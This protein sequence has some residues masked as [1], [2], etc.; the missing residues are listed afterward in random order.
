VRRAELRVSAQ[1]FA[2]QEPESN[3]ENPHTWQQSLPTLGKRRLRIAIS[4]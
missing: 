2:V 4:G 1:P 3:H